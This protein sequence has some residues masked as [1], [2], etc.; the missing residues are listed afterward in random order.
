M[1]PLRDIRRSRH[2]AG[3]PDE[4]FS[5]LIGLSGASKFRKFAENERCAE[6]A[7]PFSSAFQQIYPQASF[8][9]PSRPR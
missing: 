9:V 8:H 2:N 7:A 4:K 1:Y 5:E 3:Q 6:L